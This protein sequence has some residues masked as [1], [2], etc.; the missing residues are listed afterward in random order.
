MTE[1]QLPAVADKAALD[2]VKNA[3]EKLILTGNI[4]S[5]NETQRIAYYNAFCERLGLDPVT[6]PFQLISLQGKLTLYLDRNGAEQL[7]NKHQISMAIKESKTVEDCYVV[8]VEAATPGHLRTTEST[9]VVSI[10]G[11]KGEALCN[12]LMKAETK[13][14]RRAILSICGMGMIDESEIETIKGAELVKNDDVTEK[15]A[16]EKKSTKSTPSE[17]TASAG[18]QQQKATTSAAT[19]AEKSTTSVQQDTVK[20]SA[21][22]IEDAD[23]FNIE[24]AGQPGQEAWVS[25]EQA[26]VKKGWDAEVLENWVIDKLLAEGVLKEPPTCEEDIYTAW[27]WDFVDSCLEFVNNNAQ[28]AG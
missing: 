6:R 15:P 14:K 18:G 23:I 7:A 28:P 27:S 1:K 17:K 3:I 5:L 26:G 16:L 25:I 22:E 8:R 10:A 11:L 12:A 20:P 13:A 2:L 24:R 4:A 21:E 9:G 19:T